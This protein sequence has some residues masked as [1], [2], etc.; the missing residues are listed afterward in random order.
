[1]RDEKTSEVRKHRHRRGVNQILVIR[2]K[3]DPASRFSDDGRYRKRMSRN[4]QAVRLQ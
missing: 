4:H 1:M 2:E 3:I